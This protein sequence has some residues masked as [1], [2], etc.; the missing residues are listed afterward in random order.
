MKSKA[1]WISCIFTH[2]PN[3]QAFTDLLNRAL[4]NTLRSQVLTV[5]RSRSGGRPT[6]MNQESVRELSEG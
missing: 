5:V 1:V 4:P 2:N 6:T 3:V